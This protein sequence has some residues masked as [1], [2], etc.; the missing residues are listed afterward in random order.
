LYVYI[1]IY[2]NC[3]SSSFCF[4]FRF[5]LDVKWGSRCRVPFNFLLYLGR[6]TLLYRRR[7][8]HLMGFFLL[9]SKWRGIYTPK[10]GFSYFTERVSVLRFVKGGSYSTESNRAISCNIFWQCITTDFYSLSTLLESEIIPTVLLSF[11]PNFLKR[12]RN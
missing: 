8:I 4:V 7:V 10:L 6:L 11:H 12:K 1:V 3:F 5:S 2:L 9:I